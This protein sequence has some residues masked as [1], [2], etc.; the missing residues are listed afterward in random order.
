[1]FFENTRYLAGI[2]AWWMIVFVC[3][4]LL[5]IA[6]NLSAFPGTGTT[7]QAFVAALP[8]DMSMAG[9]FCVFT[10]LLLLAETAAGIRS[11]MA[12]R[13]LITALALTYALIAVGEAAVYSEWKSKLNYKV[14]AVLAHP[15]EF[16]AIT[17]PTHLALMVLLWLVPAGLLI[18]AWV[19]S[20][21][22][23]LPAPSGGNLR[24][25]FTRTFVIFGL[26][27]PLGVLA[28]GGIQPIP[29]SMASVYYTNHQACNDLA[30]NPGWNM[31]FQIGNSWTTFAR[32][33]P[34]E[35]MPVEDARAIT[36]QLLG[37][38]SSEVPP[39]TPGILTTKRPNIVLLILE[40][41]SAD[42]ISSITAG[43]MEFTPGF[44]DLES[45][46][47]LFTGFRANGNRSQQGITS[48]L[49][50]FPALGIVAAADD[51]GFVARLPGV[52][53]RLGALGYSSM[54]VYGGQLEYGNIKAVVTSA[55]FDRIR[56][57][58]DSFPRGLR[59]GAMGVHDGEI[60]DE[61]IASCDHMTSPFFMT[62]FTLSSHAPYD[63]PG[64]GI[65]DVPGD[66]KEAQY[67]RS[68]RYTDAALT[69]FF[70]K[71]STRPWFKDTLFI[72]VGDHGHNS[73][74]DLPSWH[75]DF[76][77]VPL[78]LTGPVIR[79]EL[80]GRKISTIGS[81]VDLPA[82]ILAQLGEDTRDFTWSRDLLADLPGRFAH[83]ELNYG[84]GFVTDDG[85]V[86]FDKSA[87]KPLLS[88][89]PS[90]GAG[91]VILRGKAYT[92]C[93][94]Q[95]FI[96]GTWCGESAAEKSAEHLLHE[97]HN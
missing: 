82:T 95:T 17:T 23:W 52:G 53:H 54:F 5:F 6:I 11:R 4:R 97:T 79:P 62:Q 36:R 66:I 93:S 85:A 10:W 76:R 25:R 18:T 37:A 9:W 43:P 14:M 32:G 83:Y 88:T 75:P 73:W 92:Q 72:L 12:H 2:L 20:C 33:N 39:P 78:L 91:R 30:V 28:R 26:F 47:I 7:A 68:M 65:E 51:L 61:V 31:F 67:A 96:D 15:T 58:E 49:T 77:R 64:D 29:V 56:S 3:F 44:K 13:A 55:G 41:W 24:R 19:K 87:G 27:I 57:G 74:R 63:F 50:G 45:S 1:M 71:A 70:K 81:Q 35:F 94:M 8:L 21:E 48:I 42:M 89:V 16:L 38:S 59:R 34:F 80:R 60:V 84:F 40:S 69:Q 46:G 86:V 22:H 90:E